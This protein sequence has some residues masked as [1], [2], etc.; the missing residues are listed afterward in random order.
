MEIRNF[1]YI[2]SGSIVIGFAYA[3][4]LIPH[5]IVPGGVS[6]I[7]IILNYFFKLP[8]GTVSLV[9]NIPILYLGVKVLGGKYGLRTIV[10]MF[11][12]NFAIDFMHEVLK[13]PSGTGNPLLASIYGG[14]LLGLGLGLV[15]KGRASTGGTDVIGMIINKWTGMSIGVGIFMVDFII[16]SCAGI[17][18]HSLEAP[19][20]GYLTLFLSSKLIDFVLEGWSYAKLAVIITEKEEEIKEFVLK[21]MGRSGT[22]LYGETFFLGKPRRVVMTVISR[23]EFPGLRQEIRKIDPNSFMIATEV[24][25]VI[26]KGFK[27]RG[28]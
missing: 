21:K 12:L 20:F 4:F 16:I 19:L 28:L 23:K 2:I 22:F 18:F 6:G 26:G 27:A 10:L 9:L 5:H 17:A 7:A 1:A 14:I 8:V 13:L 15:F 11:I 25:E 3:L 24:Y